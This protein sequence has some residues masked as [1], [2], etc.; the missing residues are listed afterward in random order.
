MAGPHPGDQ[1]SERA[2]PGARRLAE[3]PSAR[4]GPRGDAPPPDS[5][6]R[7][8][9]PGPLLRATLV[10]GLGG[11]LLVLVGA[12]L[13]S[14]AGLLF[15][16]GAT[17]AAAGLV[18]ARASA[19]GDAAAPASRRTVTWLAIGLVIAAIVVAGLATWVVALGEGG[20]LGPLDYLWTT[21]G[22]FVPGE[23]VVGALGAAWGATSGPV[24]R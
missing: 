15:V 21:F 14:L 22:P 17:G 20:V 2:E 16:A 18:L 9:L 13:A 11:V 19:P 23:L 1:A 12:V 6:A 4:Y 24:Q 3:P 8:A 5:A 7:S 10:A